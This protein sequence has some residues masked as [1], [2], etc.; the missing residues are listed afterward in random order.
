MDQPTQELQ[1][2]GNPALDQCV[3]GNSRLALPHERNG[4]L[5]TLQVGPRVS[6]YFLRFT[7]IFSGPLLQPATL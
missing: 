4:V 2:V 7:L 5:E 6:R 1:L 3:G